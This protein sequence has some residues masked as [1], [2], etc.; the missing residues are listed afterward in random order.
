VLSAV[1]QSRL[2]VAWGRDALRLG[3]LTAIHLAAFAILLWSEADG[4]ARAAFVFTWGFLNFLWL[5]L[6]QRPSTSGALS[7][8]LIVILIVLSQF[9]HDVL[10]MTATFVDVMLIDFATISF[11]VAIIPGL[12][13]KVGITILLMISLLVLLWQFEPFRV[14]RSVAL[15]GCISCFIALAGLS[16]AF[17]M[18]REDEFLLDQ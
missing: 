7:L 1:F 17:P 2:A 10:M 3:P 11:L 16:F 8:V 14:R 5:A 6:L 4:D 13:W 12:A 18:D 9:K 15:V